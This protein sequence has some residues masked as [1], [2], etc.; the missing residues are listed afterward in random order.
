[1]ISNRRDKGQVSLLAPLNK[2][3]RT[4]FL[5]HIF[6]LCH[7]PEK[8][9]V[10]VVKIANIENNAVPLYSVVMQMCQSIDP[11]KFQGF[12]LKTIE[13]ITA[14]SKPIFVLHVSE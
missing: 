2:R 7:I 10:E 9:S 4:C 8:F 14:Q 1:M 5:T 13:N 6:L 12:D 3:P 11:E